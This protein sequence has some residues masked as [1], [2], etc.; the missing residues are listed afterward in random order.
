MTNQPPPMDHEAL[1]LHLANLHHH[2]EGGEGMNE[3]E[4]ETKDSVVR[5][6]LQAYFYKKDKSSEDNSDFV[7]A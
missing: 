5:L 7:P 2:Y 1:G 4:G 3:P 6:I